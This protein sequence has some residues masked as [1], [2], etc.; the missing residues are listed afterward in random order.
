M[1]DGNVES[2]DE[3]NALID[4]SRHGE[5]DELLDLK[6]GAGGLILLG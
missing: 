2:I 6:W 3:G 4:G 1:V 5:S